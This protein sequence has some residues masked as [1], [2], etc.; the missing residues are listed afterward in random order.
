MIYIQGIS[1]HAAINGHFLERD[2]KTLYAPGKGLENLTYF[3]ETLSK[4]QQE[5]I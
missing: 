1:F 4:V 5:A 2:K 3:S